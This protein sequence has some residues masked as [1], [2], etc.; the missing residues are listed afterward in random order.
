MAKN[1]IEEKTIEKLYEENFE[2]I[3]KFFYYKVLSREIAEDL[4]SEAFITFVQLIKDQKEINNLQ[5][6]LYGIAKNI[7][8]KYLKQKYR[9]GIPFSVIDDDFENY[10]DKYVQ[11]V[12][13]KETLEDKAK[14][15]ID[16]L[17]ERQREVVTLRL[18]EKLSLTEICNK[19]GK[20]MN[21]VKTTQKRALASLKKYVELGIDSQSTDLI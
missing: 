21:Y 17:P 2:R 19:L 7:F 15:Y 16:R 18:I 1:L 11:E 8:L 13:S 5:A 10:T 12:E 6:F 9:D 4:T 14:P 20:D 3:Y